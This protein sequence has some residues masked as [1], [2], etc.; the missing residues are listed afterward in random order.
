MSSLGYYC[1]SAKCS[2]NCLPDFTCCCKPEI[3]A[4]TTQM[5]RWGLNISPPWAALKT[6]H[7]C[8]LPAF[9]KKWLV[10]TGQLILDCSRVSSSSGILL[11]ICAVYA[12]S[13][14]EIRGC[15]LRKKFHSR[16]SYFEGE[17]HRL[18][19]NPSPCIESPWMSKTLRSWVP[20][21]LLVCI[22]SWDKFSW[23]VEVNFPIS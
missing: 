3:L 8:R 13:H 22:N 7:A 16:L 21:C 9:L 12:F 11:L 20:V 2:C 17:V 18:G 10:Y 4:F 23:R 14:F 6:C 19:V 5:C 15:L 1:L